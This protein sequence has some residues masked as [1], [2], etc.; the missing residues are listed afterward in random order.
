MGTAYRIVDT[1]KDRE[2]W[3]EA[4][5]PTI[6]GSEAPAVVGLSRFGSPLSLY[7]DKILGAE[8]FDNDI[9]RFGRI[10]E[11]QIARDYA[12]ATGRII[13]LD[14]RLLVSRRY[15][16]MSCTLDAVQWIDRDGRKRGR[17]LGEFKT[18]LYGWDE[19][20]IPPDNWCQIQHQFAVT[21]FEWGTAI[22]FNRTNCEM[23]HKDV[24][25]DEKY[26]ATLVEAER[27]FWFDNVIAGVAP[28]ADGH[29]ATTK[30]LKRLY[31]THEAGELL[32]FPIEMLDARDRR[33]HIVETVFAL[34][35]EKV[36]IDNRF[37]QVIGDAEG[38]R[39]PDGTGFNYKA[40][41]NGVRSLRIKE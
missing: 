17:G 14:G 9:V 1:G 19:N 20:G 35:E 27:E 25:P 29:A 41:K 6:G 5:Q 32:A 21:M 22:M 31:P 37:K 33:A 24:Y 16:W 7:T 3:L 40:N 26:I 8:P 34:S 23:V 12:A 36:A 13:K 18:S 39:F 30:A 2:K 15:P 10:Y 11:R 38:G 4:R 28:D